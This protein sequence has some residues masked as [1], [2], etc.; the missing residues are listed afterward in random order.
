MTYQPRPFDT[1]TVALPSELIALREIL[2]ENTHENWSAQ[3]IRDGW[4]YGPR[5]DDQLKQHPGLVPYKEL[6]EQ[7]KEYDRRTSEEVLKTI[8]A[9]G[10]EVVPVRSG[11]PVSSSGS[12]WPKF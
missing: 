3:R 10:F 1:A 6:S 2:A 12:D 5:R 11:A 8:I 9:C 7:E 4:S